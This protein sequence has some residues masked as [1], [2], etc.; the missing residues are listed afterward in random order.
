M[1][2]LRGGAVGPQRVRVHPQVPAVPARRQRGG[3][4]PQLHL[5][6]RRRIRAAP[7][8]GTGG[9]QNKHSTVVEHPPVS[10]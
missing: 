1:T 4:Q 7:R 8:R 3:G 6:L 10:S 9:I 2:F 5:R